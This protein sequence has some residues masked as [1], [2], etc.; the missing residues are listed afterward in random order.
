N[1]SALR[2]DSRLAAAWLDQLI[3]L[4][5]D[6]AAVADLELRG[7]DLAIF[8]H[9]RGAETDGFGGPKTVDHD[10]LRHVLEQT[11]LDFPAPHDSRRNDV[12]DSREI[13]ATRLLV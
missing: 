11:L 8:R 5:K 10:H 6:L 12:D 2:D 1:R 7:L 4:I 13:K 9:H 3:A